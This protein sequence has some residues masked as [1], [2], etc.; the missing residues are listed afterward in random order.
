[1]ELNYTY[2]YKKNL[3]LAWPIIV[4]QMGHMMT[5]LADSVMVGQ[6]GAIS[7][8]AASLSG[9]IVAV[10]MVFGM[11]ISF[12]ATPFVAENDRK[13]KEQDLSSLLFNGSIL[14]ISV[15]ILIALLLVLAAPILNYMNQSPEVVAEAIPYFR[16][17]GASMLPVIVFM[18]FKQYAEGLSKTQVAMYISILGN[19]LNIGLNVIFIYGI[20]GLIPAYGLKGAGI[21]TLIAR[22]LMSLFMAFYVLVIIKKQRRLKL[23]LSLFD[24]SKISEMFRLGLPIAGQMVFEVGAFAGASVMAGWI[25]PEA[26]AAHQIVIVLASITYMA[27]NGLGSAATVR[28]GNQIGL[29]DFKTMRIAASSIFHMVGAIMFFFAIIFVLTR[30]IL[31]AFFIESEEVRK[32]CSGLMILAALFQ[33]SDGLQVAALGSLRGLKDVKW[34]SMLSLF[35]YWFISLPLGYVFAFYFDMGVNGLWIS[36]CIALALAAIFLVLR[37]YRKAAL[38]QSSLSKSSETEFT[39]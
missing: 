6:L 24:F 33:L 16:Y 5:H 19:V 22:I 30:N 28:V 8:A 3:C 17:L 1:M 31:P 15:G 37:F 9:S 26:Q 13:G 14:H 21:A 38:L 39:Q 29:K 10:I 4:G 18:S 27:A 25:S 32:I 36:F 35:T 20:E 2:Y 7:L 11:G 23:S 12:S 34:P